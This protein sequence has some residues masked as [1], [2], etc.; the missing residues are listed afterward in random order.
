MKEKYLRP[1]V[2]SA[3]T[4]YGDGIIP[5]G[6]AAAPAAALLAG[7]AVGRAVVKVLEARPVFK[8]PSLT[9]GRRVE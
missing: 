7:Y 1:A 6:A 3:S 4:L 9:E 2:I 8:L 5:L